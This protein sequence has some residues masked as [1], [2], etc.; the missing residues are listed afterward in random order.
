MTTRDRVERLMPARGLGTDQEERSSGVMAFQRWQNG[1]QTLLRRSVVEGQGDEPLVRF[2]P[3]N[4]I[5]RQRKASGLADF[6][7]RRSDRQP[8]THRQA[9]ANH[10]SHMKNAPS[11]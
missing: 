4:H 11:P 7:Q 8:D 3:A 6:D 1:V 2:H 9:Q 5:A 10:F